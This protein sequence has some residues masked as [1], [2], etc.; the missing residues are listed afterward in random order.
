LFSVTIFVPEKG[1]GGGCDIMIYAVNIK[2]NN[3]NV[4]NIEKST[5]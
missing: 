1:N 3:K 2:V 4:N 5:F